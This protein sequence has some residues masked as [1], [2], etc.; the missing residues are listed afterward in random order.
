MNQSKSGLANA[1]EPLAKHQSV[2]AR[3]PNPAARSRAL[4][5]QTEKLGN[6][7]GWSEK[8]K[9]ARSK[10]FELLP[11]IRSYGANP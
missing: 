9:M 11:Q 1:S 3:M 6:T 4:V 10:R 7:T 8:E 5:Q 2:P